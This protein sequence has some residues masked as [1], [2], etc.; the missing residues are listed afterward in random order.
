M[1]QLEREALG[2]V[3]RAPEG[4]EEL[5]Q[6]AETEAAVAYDEPPGPE[7]SDAPDEEFATEVQPSPAEEPEVALEQPEVVPGEPELA[8][9]EAGV[10]EV[11][12]EPEVAP[13]DQQ[14]GFAVFDHEADAEPP[15]APAPPEPVAA[16]P[17][18]PEPEA[19]EPPPPA[20][21]PPAPDPA[22]A[23]S[24]PEPDP[25]TAP[26]VPEPDLPDHLDE[27]TA[28]Y[29]VE[30]EHAQERRGGHP[31]GEGQA[32]PK[33]PGEDV[34]E[35]TPEFLQDTPDHDRLWFEQRPPK[36]FDFDE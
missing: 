14:S 24:A 15:A 12:L 17:P 9:E 5:S 4:S 11:A 31:G 10:P 20:T 32:A 19:A 6:G 36:D 28:E 25:A 34:L 16:E 1:E 26:P 23:S 35:E 2:P 13:A 33:K 18:A 30:A 21:P 29:D 7:W 3:R 27:E 22:A 8:P